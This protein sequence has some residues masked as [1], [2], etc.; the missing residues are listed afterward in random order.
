MYGNLIS[1]PPVGSHSI[2]KSDENR[3][4]LIDGKVM[5]KF[6][7]TEYALILLF[8]EGKVVEDAISIEKALGYEVGQHSR[9]KLDEHIDHMRSKLSGSGLDIYRVTRRGYILLDSQ[10]SSIKGP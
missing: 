6:T 4:I 10:E 2:Q 9:E 3:S 5:I 7:R 8:L 1:C